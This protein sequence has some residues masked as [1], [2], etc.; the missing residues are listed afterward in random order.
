MRCFRR[1]QR[2]GKNKSYR[3][4][5]VGHLLAAIIFVWKG[6]LELSAAVL[7]NPFDVVRRPTARR[8]LEDA[9]GQQVPL[10]GIGRSGFALHGGQVLRDEL[11]QRTLIYVFFWQ[12]NLGAGRSSVGE[13]TDCNDDI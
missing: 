9:S 4:V 12:K 2:I 7:V 3:L 11:G 5:S 13:F 6:V 10:L 8:S 1:T